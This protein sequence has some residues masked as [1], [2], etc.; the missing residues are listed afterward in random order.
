MKRLILLVASW[1]FTG[2]IV[3]QTSSH[4]L[5][6][7]HISEQDGLADNSV[8]CFYQDSRGIMWMGTQYG[9]NS[10]DG[11]A[12][13]TYRYEAENSP[14]GVF[15]NEIHAIA[16]DNKHE[17][18][19]A[20][21]NGLWN[22][23]PIT[24]KIKFYRYKPTKGVF[25]NHMTGLVCDNGKV[26]ISTQSGLLLFDP[27]QKIFTRFENTAHGLQNPG[28][29]FSSVLLD[30]KKRL[31]LAATDGVW[32]FNRGTHTFECYDSPQNDKYFDGAITI[33]EDHANNIWFGCWNKGFKQL[34]PDTKS[35]RCLTLP[36]VLPS[37]ILSITE[38]KENNGQY[39]IWLSGGLTKLSPQTGKSE[40]F[41]LKPDENEA[42]LAPLCVYV[43][44]DN[45]LWIATVKGVYIADLSKQYFNT[46]FFSETL[47]DQSPVLFADKNDF[48]LG[49]KGKNILALY[50]DNFKIIKD[51]APLFRS[52]KGSSTTNKP[53][54]TNITQGPKDEL[55]LSTSEGMMVLHQDKISIEVFNHKDN[56]PGSLPRNFINNVVITDENE[57]WCLPWRR[58]V[59]RFNT[60]KHNFTPLVIE[61]PE[62]SKS[63]KKLNV[64]YAVKDS[65]KNI[66]FADID[67][68]LVKYSAS[69]KKFERFISPAIRPE[70]RVVNVVYKNGKLLVVLSNSA[71]LVIDPRDNKLTSWALPAFMNKDVYDYDTDDNGNLWIATGTGLIVFDPVMHSFHQYTELDGLVN[72]HMDG[73]L[74]KLSSG[75]MAYAAENYVTEF[76]PSQV[77]RKPSRKTVLLTGVISGDGDVL[78]LSKQIA[79]PYDAEK[80]SF[81]WALL[82]YS[83]PFKNSYY[84]KLNGIDKEWHLCGNKGAIEYNSLPAGYYLFHYKAATADGLFSPDKVIAF[85]VLPPF[86]QTW[87]FRL[88]FILLLIF[89]VWL[90]VRNEKIKEQKKAALQIQFS[91]LEMKALRA[92]MNPHFIFNALNSIQECIVTKH[93]DNAYHYLTTFSKLVRMILEN[94]GKQFITLQEEIQTLSLYL[95]LEKLRFDERF[96]YSITIDK[97]IDPSFVKIPAMIVQPYAENALWHGLIHK[98]GNKKL[99]IDF[100]Q[101]E[102]SLVCLIEDNGIGRQRSAKLKTSHKV[103]KHSMGMH[104]TEE[105]LALL[106]TG[107]QV[108]IEDIAAKNNST[109]T[110]VTINFP[111]QY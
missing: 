92:Q 62:S 72:N 21:T 50:D 53:T 97:S 22:F 96:E 60:K 76:M 58:G 89:V 20:T 13:Y 83:N 1:F 25:S 80:I 51:Y 101:H 12:I 35:V 81:T 70:S 37:Q 85:T 103:N 11:S 94:S 105:R 43:S 30:S 4:K 38:Q 17:L 63:L 23:N 102:N 99:T 49:G 91:Q 66:W 71:V 34:L 77:L 64:F 106:A 7:Y 48:W 52:L 61:L 2:Q 59:W 111:F 33:F 18:W 40:S 47:S 74:R 86:W 9:L 36:Q 14:E 27:G 5:L 15:D 67:F 69:T 82:N 28:S 110:K 3:A 8:N 55:F 107:A 73:T 10:F 44:S 68:G 42:P 56:D 100:K 109:G 75:K 45:L 16:E 84:C 104:I 88:L 90:I 46:Y 24:K 19:L 6:F 26:W 95:S 39:V 78:H 57:L 87:W 41:V 31:W 79:V 93:T 65:L 98:Q 108:T 54:V 32:L 29:D